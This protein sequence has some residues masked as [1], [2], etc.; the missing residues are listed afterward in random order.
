MTREV[1][2]SFEAAI[3]VLSLKKQKKMEGEGG[4]KS[5]VAFSLGV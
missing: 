4:S 5:K 2:W 3:N 1:V